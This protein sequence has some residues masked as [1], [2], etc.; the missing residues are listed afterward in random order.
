MI[1]AAAAAYSLKKTINIPNNGM[2][3]AAFTV[4]NIL[5]KCGAVKRGKNICAK[6]ACPSR[7]WQAV[8][9]TVCVSKF[10]S[11]FVK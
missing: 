8:L 1:F 11:I 3:N 2:R 4:I 9:A 7:L 6:T 5:C 10:H